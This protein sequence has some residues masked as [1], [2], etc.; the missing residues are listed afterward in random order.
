M[1]AASRG[2]VITGVAPVMPGTE[3]VRGANA[4][5]ARLGQPEPA[6][7]GEGLEVVGSVEGGV[8]WA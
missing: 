8:E 6:D 5:A 1:P 3:M 2:G 4:R 7:R